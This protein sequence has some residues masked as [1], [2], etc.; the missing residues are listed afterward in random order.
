M[1]SIQEMRKEPVTVIELK[2]CHYL[3]YMLLLY[4]PV[5]AMHYFINHYDWTLWL[6]AL[7]AIPLFGMLFMLLAPGVRYR[8]T[9]F[10]IH[11]LMIETMRGLYYHKRTVTPLDRIQHVKI[12]QG[13]IASRFGLAKVTLVTSGDQLNLPY[14]STA[15][16]ER[17]AR[18]IIERIK[19]VTA[20]V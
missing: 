4:I 5:V 19:E 18:L 9:A 13:P 6:L 15:E 17:L 8:H 2:R 20:Y 11:P 7:Y 12:T 16:A 14:V 10:Y 1:R 3:M